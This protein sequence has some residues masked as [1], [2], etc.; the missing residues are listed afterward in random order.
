MLYFLLFFFYLFF[1]VVCVV[2]VFLSFDY[3]L[4]DECN[5]LTESEC[6]IA[7]QHCKMAALL[8]DR[9]AFHP[10]QSYKHFYT[11][12]YSTKISESIVDRL[13][14]YMTFIT[15]QT[16]YRMHPEIALFSTKYVYGKKL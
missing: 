15:L 5:Q 6:L 10:N 13:S 14:E 16:Q 3:G 12:K 9:Q 8:Q 1:I 2:S 11:G 4:F 7:L